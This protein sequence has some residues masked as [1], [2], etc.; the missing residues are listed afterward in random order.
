MAAYETAIGSPHETLLVNA[1][2]QMAAYVTTIGW[3]HET[4]LIMVPITTFDF[5]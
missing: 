1:R 4:L 2:S 3:L 5:P